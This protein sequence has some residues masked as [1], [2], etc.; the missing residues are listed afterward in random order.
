MDGFQGILDES[1][2]LSLPEQNPDLQLFSQTHVIAS[3]L[4]RHLVWCI[5]V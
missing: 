1:L 5:L 2:A 3:M 4:I